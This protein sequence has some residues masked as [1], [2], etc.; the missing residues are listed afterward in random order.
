MCS[1]TCRFASEARAR[2]ALASVLAVLWVIPAHAGASAAADAA[3]GAPRRRIQGIDLGDYDAAISEF[4]AAYNLEPDPRILYNLG[5]AY[6][7]RYKLTA[8]RADLVR[9]RDAFS[10]FLSL[11]SRDDP[12]FAADPGWVDKVTA[13]AARYRREVEAE[14]AASESGPAPEKPRPARG[15]SNRSTTALVLLA[16]A[17][18]AGLA[19]GVTGVLAWREGARSEDRADRGEFAEANRLASRSDTLALTTDVLIGV[20]AVSATVGLVLWLRRSG[21]RGEVSAV[22]GR[23]AFGLAVSF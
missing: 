11:V 4:N 2:L 19:A 3:A 10:N 20:A 13:L 21:S 22:T 18:A 5:L 16:S 1:P 7:R 17:G 23:R 14:L 12:R 9:A 8:D 15:A 6:R